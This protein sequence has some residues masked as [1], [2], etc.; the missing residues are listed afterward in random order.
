M[1]FLPGTSA[2]VEDHPRRVKPEDALRI[3]TAALMEG[4]RVLM[5]ADGVL[6]ERSLTSWGFK[7]LGLRRS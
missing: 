6:T 5:V 1:Q 2:D 7:Q 4:N 3:P